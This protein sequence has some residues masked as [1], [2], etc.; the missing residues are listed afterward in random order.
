[1]LYLKY[2]LGGICKMFK[3]IIILL[4]LL[5]VTIVSSA[6]T[7]RLSV[8]YSGDIDD[9][10]ATNITLRTLQAAN[11]GDE[12]YIYLTS[13]GGRTD[14]GYKLVSAI[15]HSKAKVVVVV[16][17]WAASM[18]ANIVCEA[19]HYVVYPKAVLMFHMAFYVEDGKRVPLDL[20]NPYD[21]QV[22]DRANQ[23]FRDCGFLTEKEIAY[24]DGGGEVYL[25]GAQI[26]SRLKH[27]GRSN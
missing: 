22:Y 18:A 19:P 15:Q 1:M 24:M 4:T 23:N 26:Q 6:D 16:K 20:S 12:V 8:L 27:M 10:N 5:A 25:T 13:D 21:R 7:L 17:T 11:T 2:S 3:K 9:N 14:I